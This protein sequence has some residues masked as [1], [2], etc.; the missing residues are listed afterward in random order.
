MSESFRF[1]QEK[2]VAK[3]L[4]S[5]EELEKTVANF[6]QWMQGISK[7]LAQTKSELK[8]MYDAENK[9]L[10]KEQVCLKAQQTVNCCEMILDLLS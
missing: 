4:S 7:Q 3:F 10:S 2:N 1:Y 5:V 8:E 6:M 9:L